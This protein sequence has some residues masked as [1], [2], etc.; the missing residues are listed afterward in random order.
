MEAYSLDLRARVMQAVEEG[1]DTRKEIAE[2]F[3]VTTRWIRKLVEQHRKTGSIEPR[4]H[5]G[6]RQAT[7]TPERLKRLKKLV[8]KKPGATL[9]ELR[10]SSRVPCCR[11]TVHRALQQLG[12][13]RKKRRYVPV[14]KIV[15]R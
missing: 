1:I 10:K 5:A 13:T 6:G 12:F 3:G 9:D 15:P 7:F 11:M 8:E 14:S 2:N 4:P